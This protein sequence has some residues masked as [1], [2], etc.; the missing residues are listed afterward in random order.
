MR[1]LLIG[2][3][4]IL[5]ISCTA[6]E[7]AHYSIAHSENE[8]IGRYEHS[9]FMYSYTLLLQDSLKY[10]AIERSDIFSERTIGTWTILGTT[11]TLRPEKKINTIATDRRVVQEM[12]ITDPKEQNV[13]I[14]TSNVLAISGDNQYLELKRQK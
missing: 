2:Q 14:V 6:R 9:S 10:V 3:L 11:V 13:M 1:S 7:S 5:L 8:M 4:L 12:P